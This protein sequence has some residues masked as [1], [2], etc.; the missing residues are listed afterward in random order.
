MST[1]QPSRYTLAVH[2]SGTLPGAFRWTV[3]EWGK[4]IGRSGVTVLSARDARRECEAALG[5]AIRAYA[6]G[7]RRTCH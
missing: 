1:R 7:E 3:S 6:A 5:V 2:P 4:V